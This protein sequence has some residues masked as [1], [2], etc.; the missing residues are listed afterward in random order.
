MEKYCPTE[1]VEESEFSRW[2]EEQGLTH[3]HVPQETYTDSW[4]QKA[5]NKSLGV[6]EGVS[7]H[8][9]IIP[10]PHHPNG[11]LIVIE[12]KRQFGNTPTPAQIK[13]LLAL[14]AVDNVG[15]VCCYGCEEAK[16]LVLE[17]QEGDFT[18]YDKCWART[19]KLIEERAK[20]AENK[21]K[22]AKK[23]VKSPKKAENPK[24]DLP[25]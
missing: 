7:D 24:N 11:S 12:F 9:V 16:Q 2:C 3:W 8:W 4:K 22:S 5:H 18:T 17:M 25:Y 19:N 13:F 1:D 23:R 14:G 21:A 10:T 20:R 15:T 6:L